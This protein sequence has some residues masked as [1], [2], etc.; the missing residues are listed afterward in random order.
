MT[1]HT[2]LPVAGYKPQSEE[3]VVLANEGKALEERYLRWLDKLDNE[4]KR[5]DAANAV[6]F[7]KPTHDR[8]FIA[9][10]RTHIQTGAMFAIR[11]IFRPG[12]INLP[13]DVEVH[14]P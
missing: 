4:A 14:H 10:A 9:L 3:N 6:D 12:R 11:S 8:R 2:G 7:V 13:D 1:Q 5:L